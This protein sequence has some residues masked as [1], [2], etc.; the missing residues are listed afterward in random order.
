MA[1]VRSHTNGSASSPQLAA[2]LA[3]PHALENL[4]RQVLEAGLAGDRRTLEHVC[5]AF[6]RLPELTDSRAK[7][8]GATLELADVI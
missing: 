2:P 6:D 3:R 4:W 1:A 8:S 5:L 7:L